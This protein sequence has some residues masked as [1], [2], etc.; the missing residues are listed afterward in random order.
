MNYISIRREQLEPGA[1]V[2]GV[3]NS[4]EPN[5]T[6]I[7]IQA[8]IAIS[9]KRIADALEVT[10]AEDN[11]V[12]SLPSALHLLV[13]RYRRIFPAVRLP[14]VILWSSCCELKS[15]GRLRICAALSAR[16]GISQGRLQGKAG[17][18]H[19]HSISQPTVIPVSC[20]VNSC[21]L[22]VIPG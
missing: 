3:S 5:V 10:N 19:Q 11:K 16:F 6:E 21:G 20:T 14:L 8:S 13:L 7:R 15:M 2:Q 4:P 17:I 22:Q 9:L 1:L 12:I 18:S